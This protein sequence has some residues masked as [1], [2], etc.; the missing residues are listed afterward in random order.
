M[1]IIRIDHF[2][3]TVASIK[4]AAV[5][6][7]KALGIEIQ[8]FEAADGT[9]RYAL[10]LGDSKINFHELGYEFEPKALH[11]TPGSADLCLVLEGSMKELVKNLKSE[12]IPIELGPVK[13]TGALGEISSVYIRD[14]DMNLVEIAIYV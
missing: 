10:P 7:K 6:Y 2:V 1:K 4:R 5:F 12:N 8:E 9:L 3:L 13:R 14:L 11:V